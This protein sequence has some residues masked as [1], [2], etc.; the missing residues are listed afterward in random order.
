MYKI[1]IDCKSYDLQSYIL[2]NTSLA[3]KADAS[4]THNTI[5]EIDT[6]TENKSPDWYRSNYDMQFIL[7]FKATN[8]IGLSISAQFV[9]VITMVPWHDASGGNV[10]QRA[11]DY[12]NLKEYIRSGESTSWSAW[13]AD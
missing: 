7:E 10:V 13:K 2:S 5:Y 12:I 9:E 1:T 11:I 4:H 3:K 8:A 6:R